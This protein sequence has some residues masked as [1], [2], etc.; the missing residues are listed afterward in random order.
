[1]RTTTEQRDAYVRTMTPERE[2]TFTFDLIADVEDLL[3]IVNGTEG[4]LASCVKDGV[5]QMRDVDRA[6]VYTKHLGKK[7]RP[8]RGRK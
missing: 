7:L 2:G 6:K 4:I 3:V 8:A 5:L 1:M